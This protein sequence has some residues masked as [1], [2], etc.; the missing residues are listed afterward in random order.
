GA[1]GYVRAVGAAGTVLRFSEGTELRL[2][3]GARGRLSAVDEHGARFAIEEGEAAVHVV[4]RPGARWLVDAGP[5]LI[6]VRG[7][8]FT[9]RWDGGRERLDLR[10]E[11]GLVSVTGPLTEGTIS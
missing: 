7:T 8:V 2:P 6:T 10:L 5:F 4:P 9:A 11:K 1:G 3:A